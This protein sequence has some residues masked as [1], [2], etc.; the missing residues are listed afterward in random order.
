MIKLVIDPAFKQLEKKLSYVAGIFNDL[1]STD[2]EVRIQYGAQGQCSISILPGNSLSFF[3][4]TWE[5]PREIIRVEWKRRSIPVF[6]TRTTPRE[7]ISHN[8]AGKH[9]IINVDILSSAFYVL[10]CWQE[11]HSN[12]K[13]R[14]GRFPGK[15]SILSELKVINIPIVNYYFD[16]LIKAIKITTGVAPKKKYLQDYT[17]TVGLT[18]D[19]DLCNTGWKENVYK[20]ISSGNFIS[21]LKIISDKIKKKDIWY[22]FNTIHEIEKSLGVNSSF[23]FI[24]EHKKVG[25]VR[26]A[27]YDIDSDDILNV[28]RLLRTAGFEIGI[29]GSFGSSTNHQKIQ[30]EINKF[31]FPIKGGRFHYLDLDLP[32]SFEV[33]ERSKLQYDSSLGFADKPGFRSGLC[34]P[35]HPYDF[36]NDRAFSF[37]EFPLVI[38]DTTLINRKYNNYSVEE[39]VFIIKEIIS[40]VKNFQGDLVLLWHNS[41]F[42]GPKYDRWRDVYIEIIDFCKKEGAFMGS[43]ESILKYLQNNE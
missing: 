31:P 16:I 1:Y 17:F 40:E 33:I 10:S 37:I 21:A 11:Y 41:S 30:S 29:H 23:Y 39:G 15:A 28:M 4:N 27:D 42:S 34:N 43:I 9:V 26:N 7:V 5:K 24:P 18:H 12:A 8:E 22:N 20:A 2:R 35:Y 3:E 38:M 36:R 6:F 13:D 25:N 19:I 32:A 14:L